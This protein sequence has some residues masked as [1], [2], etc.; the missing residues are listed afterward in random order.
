M[1]YRS[2]RVRY[3]RRRRRGARRN[4]SR[5]GS[6]Y[7]FRPSGHSWT[8]FSIARIGGANGIHYKAGA[9]DTE[10]ALLTSNCT[11]LLS[12]A[13][14]GVIA[15]YLRIQVNNVDTIYGGVTTNPVTPRPLCRDQWAAIYGNYTVLAHCLTIRICNSTSVNNVL[16]VLP[17]PANQYS[18][19]I[20]GQT[21][22]VVMQQGGAVA[23]YSQVD[24]QLNQQW[25][26]GWISTSAFDGNG[27]RLLESDVN[28]YSGTFGVS[29]PSAA[30]TYQV[31]CSNVAA[32]DSVNVRIVVTLHQRVRMWGRIKIAASSSYSAM[33]ATPAA[34]DGAV[35]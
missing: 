33:A 1:F 7:G 30:I 12:T 26:S 21:F 14:L 22:D 28:R 17:L 15:D 32:T 9:R 23:L 11:C 29:G 16:H 5:R 3:N 8:R 31:G 20:V 2:R 27:P 25:T 34:G 18:T 6:N 19:T 4:F 13:S 24:G 10:T 35:A